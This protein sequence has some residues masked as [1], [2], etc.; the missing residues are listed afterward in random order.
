MIYSHSISIQFLSSHF[1][2]LIALDKAFILPKMDDNCG[3][4]LE[5]FLFLLDVKNFHLSQYGIYIC[6]EIYL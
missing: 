5:A 1:P 4:T 2:A 3:H 6:N